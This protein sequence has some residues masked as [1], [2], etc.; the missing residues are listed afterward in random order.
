M[1][2]LLPGKFHGQRE[3]SGLE[4]P[5]GLEA[6]GLQRAGHDGVTNTYYLSMI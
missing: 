3:P 6:M 1:G 5:G 2:V 4:E